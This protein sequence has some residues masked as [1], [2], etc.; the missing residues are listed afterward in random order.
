MIGEEMKG[1]VVLDFC[2]LTQSGLSLRVYDALYNCRKI[3][4]N[5][6]AI[7]TFDFY[8]KENVFILGEDDEQSLIDFIHSDFL[9]I[10]NNILQRYSI[11]GWL[12]RFEGIG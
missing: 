11:K 8:S 7:K 10:D 1:K 9:P 4:T 2:V 12:E 5:N 6:S 3:I